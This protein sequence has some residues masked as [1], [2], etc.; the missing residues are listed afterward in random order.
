VRDYVPILAA[1][2]P[3]QVHYAN[4]RRRFWLVRLHALA[5][6]GRLATRARSSGESQLLERIFD[7]VPDM[8]FRS[9]V[10]YL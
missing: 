4:F 1:I 8:L 7:E 2:A 3:F 9:L 6:G 10:M 5:A